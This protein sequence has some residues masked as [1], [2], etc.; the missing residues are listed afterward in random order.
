MTME[1]YSETQR[2]LL[3]E[4]MANK[5]ELIVEHRNGLNIIISWLRQTNEIFLQLVDENKNE[6]LEAIIPNDSVLEARDHPY[7]ALGNQG[8]FPSVGYENES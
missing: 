2:D 5:R 7:P 6:T 3:E 4:S 8:V 1:R